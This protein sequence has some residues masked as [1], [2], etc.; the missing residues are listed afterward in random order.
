MKE[1][2]PHIERYQ[3][4]T[5]QQRN[6]EM[7]GL[8]ELLPDSSTVFSE[9]NLEHIRSRHLDVENFI[10][11]R[12]NSKFKLELTV[13]LRNLL[14]LAKITDSFKSYI[15]QWY[16]RKQGLGV[17]KESSMGDISIGDNGVFNFKIE[18][19]PNI[20]GWDHPETGG[21]F[22]DEAAK[23]IE[24]IA[25]KDAFKEELFLKKFNDETRESEEQV[26]SRREKF[27]LEKL[28]M[29]REELDEVESIDKETRDATKKF[30]K[31]EER[32]RRRIHKWR[33]EFIQ[34]YGDE[35]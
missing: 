3:A 17:A 27:R 5:P 16:A 7:R 24:I 8:F 29:S 19:T 10:A 20:F 23:P 13:R 35:P 15:F 28:L 1:T 30:L 18:Y 6:A 25:Y 33:A 26:R 22:D 31:K 14:S 11:E 2:L 21:I 4:M 9:E 34:R 12:R 32:E